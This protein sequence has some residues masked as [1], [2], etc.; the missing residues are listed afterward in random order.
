MLERLTET[1]GLG[2]MRGAI[3]PEH[4]PKSGFHNSYSRLDSRAP[5]VAVTQ[6][7]GKLSGTRCIHPFQQ[8]CEDGQRAELVTLLAR[9]GAEPRD[10]PTRDPFP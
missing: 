2:D 9:G 5:A 4:Q 7:M 8:R 10:A 6:N 3:P 1:N